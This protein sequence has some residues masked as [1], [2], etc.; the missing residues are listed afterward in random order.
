MKTIAGIDFGTSNSSVAY[1]TDKSEAKLVTLENNNTTI[2]TALFF[3]EDSQKIMYGSQAIK[4][5]IDGEYGRFMRSIKRILGSSIS[6]S[7][8]SVNGGYMKFDKI[9]SLFLKHLK[10]KLEHQ[11]GG[12]IDTVTIGRPVKFQD[13]N[14]QDKKAQEQLLAIAKMSGFK[15]ISFQY[16]PIAAAFAHERQVK[17]EVLS[18]VIDIG[19]GTS[20][21]SIIK[22]GNDLQAKIDRSSDILSNTGIRTG[23]NDF[24]KS[25]S[26]YG[27]M[28]ALGKGTTYSSKNLTVPSNVFF[29][30]SEWSEI[31]FMYVP[32]VIDIV[33][34]TLKEAHDD[35]KYSRL[36]KLLE[37]ERGHQLLQIVE[38][39]KID[40]TYNQIVSKE[41]SCV[42][43]KPVVSVKVSEFNDYIEPH[44]EKMRKSL[45]ECINL[46]AIKSTDVKLIILTGGSTEVPVVKALAKEVFPHALISD[47]NKLSSVGLGLAYDAQRKFISANL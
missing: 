12:E 11:A 29:G 36:L 44:I 43:N 47:E 27:F 39:T 17:G 9:I 15:N 21:F 41:L 28:P 6:S 8:T 13:N 38:Q 42:K 32:K 45:K 10:T 18:C 33:K 30:L 22:I 16:E 3:E 37:D 46:A 26:F 40:L 23:G 25:L 19:G 31:N 20:D 24:D 14:E 2:P 34:R 7:G 35:E 1:I 4:Q 5:F